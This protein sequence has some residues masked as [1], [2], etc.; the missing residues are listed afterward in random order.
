MSLA[1]LPTVETA[2][3]YPSHRALNG[4][5]QEISINA[6]CHSPGAIHAQNKTAVRQHLCCAGAAESQLPHPAGGPCPPGHLP[7]LTPAG[8]APPRP[9]AAALQRTASC[10]CPITQQAQVC[11]K[12][13]AKAPGSIRTGMLDLPHHARKPV[14]RGSCSAPELNPAKAL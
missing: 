13:F 3:K 7:A 5:L 1:V 14:E 8:G 4:M 9:N 12:P 11:I 10:V 6:W 2:L